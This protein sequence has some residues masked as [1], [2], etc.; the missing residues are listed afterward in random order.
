MA[1]GDRSGLAMLRDSSA[2][3]GIRKD[4]G[5][6]RA[7]M[8]NG[9]T[10]STNGWTTTAPVGSGSGRCLDVPQGA[11][12]EAKAQLGTRTGATNQIRTRR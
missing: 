6:T 4:N 5:V 2:W 11:T 12:A 1:D 3:I 10:M 8:T 9:L 7:S